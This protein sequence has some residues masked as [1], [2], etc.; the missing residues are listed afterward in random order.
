M[1]I[2][3]A[4]VAGFP[5]LCDQQKQSTMLRYRFPLLLLIAVALSACGRTVAGI[6]ISAN[7]EFVLGEGR[8]PAYQ[9][10]LNNKD[11]VAVQVSV[12]NKKTKVQTQGFD[13]AGTATVYVAADE[14]VHLINN[15]D[16]EV[17]VKATLNRKN[18]QGMR[19]LPVRD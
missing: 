16:Q 15:S 13:L 17:Q 10:R 12:R 9:A 1:V 3:S 11:T 18:I 14:E 7:Q 2:W 19:Y 8:H 4:G 5:V 6:G